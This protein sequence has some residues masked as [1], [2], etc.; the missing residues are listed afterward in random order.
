MNPIRKASRRISMLVNKITGGTVQ[1]ENRGG[2]PGQAFPGMAEAARA[3]AADGAVLLKTT[4][5]CRWNKALA[6]HSSAEFRRT[7]FMWDTA[8]AATCALRIL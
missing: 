2:A 1:N 4:V 7:G 8:P 6:S 5:P 3:A